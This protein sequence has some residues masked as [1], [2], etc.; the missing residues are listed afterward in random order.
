M[1]WESPDRLLWLLSLPPLALFL[2][3][4]LRR[5]ARLLAR[6]I[7]PELQPAILPGF[8][9]HN[10]RTATVSGFIAIAALM[11]AAAGPQ[12]GFHWEKV[13]RRGLNILIALDVSK[14]MLAP[15]FKPSRL[16]Q[17][18]WGIKD[19]IQVLHGDR[20]GLLVFAG[21]SH[22]LCPLTVDYDAFA[23]LLDDAS[24]FSVPRPGT[25][26]EKAIRHAIN[27]LQKE[28]TPADKVI[29]LITDGEDHEGNPLATLNEL[30]KNNIKVFA[31]GIGTPEGELI[32]VRDETGN[33][34]YLKDRQGHVVKSRLNEPLLRSLATA[35]GGEY[36]RAQ[37]G[38][39]GLV[40]LYKKH[41][42]GLTADVLQ[43][44][45]LKVYHQRYSIFLAISLACL[46][47]EA[48]LSVRRRR[49]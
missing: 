16:Q 39:M 12:W 45:R 21:T 24:V 3:Y 31:I 23:M 28:Q 10:R 19:L 25:A 38:Q 48:W 49:K 18:K 11:L 14:S 5:Q 32:P 36:V 7:N 26:I 34:Y 33:T 8:S 30:R 17:A 43:S 46:T 41:I 47:A 29:V 40:A 15:D 9:R 27:I 6:L 35:T 42:A 20:I 22:L 44:G 1:K 37:P 13:E 2:A 4:S